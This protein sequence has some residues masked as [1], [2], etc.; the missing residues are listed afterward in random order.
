M[1]VE[2]VGGKSVGGNY[3]GKKCRGKLWITGGKNES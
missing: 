2:N 1:R 3:S